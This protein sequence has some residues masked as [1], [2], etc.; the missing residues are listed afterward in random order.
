MDVFGNAQFGEGNGS[1]LLSGIACDGNEGSIFD[2]SL[3]VSHSCGHNQD[4]GVRCTNST[5]SGK[6]LTHA[7]CDIMLN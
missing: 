6:H 3:K 5:I 4:V 1:V 7:H 2:C